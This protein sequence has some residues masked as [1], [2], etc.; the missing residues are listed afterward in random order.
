M[1]AFVGSRRVYW[2]PP[3]SPGIDPVRGE[4]RRREPVPDPPGGGCRLRLLHR[5]MTV[6]PATQPSL[7]NLRVPG[8]RCALHPPESFDRFQYT[9]SER[10][11]CMNQTWLATR[12]CTSGPRTRMEP[13]GPSRSRT[14]DAARVAIPLLIAFAA[15]SSLVVERARPSQFPILGNGPPGH[16][17][18]IPGPA[19]SVA[20][21]RSS[22]LGGRH[23]RL[24]Q[25]RIRRNALHRHGKRASR[26]RA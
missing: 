10:P 12:S 15:P 26:L 22:R 7:T 24:R 1:Q 2:G 16:V 17:R 5:T 14:A 13:P 4:M 25:G 21:H 20:A 6:S 18:P 19:P 23:R 3:E 9:G 8:A 11:C